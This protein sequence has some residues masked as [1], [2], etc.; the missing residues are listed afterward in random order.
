MARTKDDRRAG[1]GD[2][3]KT[4][5]YPEVPGVYREMLADT[6]SSPTQVS[7]EGKT[8]KRRRVAGRIVT[9]GNERVTRDR[10]NHEQ[11][12]TDND[13]DTEKYPLKKNAPLEQTAYDES[14]DSADSDVDWE[15]VDLTHNFKEGDSSEQD[16][17]NN[18]EL[19]IV[20]G[21]D[22]DRPHKQEILKRR[23]V[24]AAERQLRFEI[25]KMHLLSLLIHVHIRNHWCND[26][27]VHVCLIHGLCVTS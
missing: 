18:T 20:L 12:A 22:S 25:H 10:F 7:E 6:L 16:D 26:G 8:V 13:T 14:E 9:R 2:A 5:T 4:N 3:G 19:N 1:R 24:T 27:K 11:G 23:P 17:A 21:N 15:E